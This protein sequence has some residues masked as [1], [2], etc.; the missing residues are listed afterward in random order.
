MV[1]V[2]I[3]SGTVQHM[4]VRSLVGRDAA[5]R[6]ALTDQGHA[7]SMVMIPRPL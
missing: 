5:G 1:R 4:I 3:R 2:G 6:L 7:V